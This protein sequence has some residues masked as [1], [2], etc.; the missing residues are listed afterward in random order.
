MLSCGFKLWTKIVLSLMIKLGLKWTK[1]MIFEKKDDIWVNY[2]CNDNFKFVW[3][4]Y[5]LKWFGKIY[6]NEFGSITSIWFYEFLVWIR[7]EA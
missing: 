7:E 1:R 2:N 6:E 3:K 4:L 5:L